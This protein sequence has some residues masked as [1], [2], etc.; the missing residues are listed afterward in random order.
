[1]FAKHVLILFMIYFTIDFTDKEHVNPFI[2]KSTCNM[3]YISLFYT[4]GYITYYYSYNISNGII[5]IS[6]YRHYLSKLTGNKKLDQNLKL[7]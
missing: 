6:N 2:S 5:F 4:H 1:M 3:D 7:A